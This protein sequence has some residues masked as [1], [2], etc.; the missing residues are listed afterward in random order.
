LKVGTSIVLGVPVLVVYFLT[1]SFTD[2][3][4]FDHESSCFVP[5]RSVVDLLRLC[6]VLAVFFLVVS[7]HGSPSLTRPVTSL[8]LWSGVVAV[9]TSTEVL[10]ASGDVLLDLHV[11]ITEADDLGLLPVFDADSRLFRS[12]GSPE[13]L[14]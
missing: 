10:A 12:T 1:V 7:C 14:V 4:F 2:L 11:G 5:V 3:S 13:G 9:V 8:G 6:M